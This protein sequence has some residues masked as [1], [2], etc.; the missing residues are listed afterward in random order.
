M[1]KIS[2]NK[3]IEEFTTHFTEDFSIERTENIDRDKLAAFSIEAYKDEFNRARFTV[4]DE[5]LKLWKWKYDNNPATGKTKNF[6]WTATY[7]GKVLGQLSIMP[8]TIKVGKRYY[9]GA[10]GTDLAILKEYRN[11]GLSAF[12]I[13]R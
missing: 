2:V 11:L 9:P 3:N 8:A 12:L 10:W 5:I 7:K 6:G 13:Q 4:R 1:E